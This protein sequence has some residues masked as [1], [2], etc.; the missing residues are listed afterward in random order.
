MTRIW[1]LWFQG[2]VSGVR[3]VTAVPYSSGQL[4]PAW[5]ACGTPCRRCTERLPS[6][7]GTLAP[8]RA[9]LPACCRTWAWLRL[10]PPTPPHPPASVSAGPCLAQVSSAVAAPPG[11][12]R[13]PAC[14]HRWRR[15]GA[16]AEAASSGA[17]LG[18]HSWASRPC[19]A[20]PASACL[21]ARTPWSHCASASTCPNRLPSPASHPHPW[22]TCRPSPQP[23]PSTSLMNKFASPRLVDLHHPAPLTPLQS[24]SVVAVRAGSPAV[25]HSHVSS[26]LRR[27]VWSA[28]DPLTHTN[29]GLRWT[30][31]RW[32]RLV[33]GFT[34]FV[35][36]DSKVSH[37]APGRFSY[38]FQKVINRFICTTVYLLGSAQVKMVITESKTLVWNEF[39]QVNA[40]PF[41]KI[42]IHFTWQKNAAY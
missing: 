6:G 2:P 4:E 26:M 20:V 31:L 14:G 8:S 39:L 35:W 37:E 41:N 10:P 19:S 42:K 29:R 18:T 25:A 34:S 1:S 27:L 21:P 24:W 5:R 17:A 13:A 16:T 9:Q 36:T 3:W 38:N 7:T 12:L 15:G 23:S 11:A 32:P 33:S 22:C 40:E 30:W 28:G